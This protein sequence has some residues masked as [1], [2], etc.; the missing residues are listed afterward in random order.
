MFHLLYLML[1][2]L[3]VPVEIFLIIV[4]NFLSL[5]LLRF[6]SLSSSVMASPFLSFFFLALTILSDK[7]YDD[8]LQVV[9]I[10]PVQPPVSSIFR[11]TSNTATE[12][13]Q[14][15]PYCPC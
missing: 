3:G 10:Q 6:S 12:P 8:T 7:T 11:S 5:S 13:N 15:W 14:N 4:P 9:Y 1:Y 2:F